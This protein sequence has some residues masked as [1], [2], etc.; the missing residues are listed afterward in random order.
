MTQS[1]TP[2]V[3][4][5]MGH[6]RRW[7]L[8]Q[9]LARSD[10]TVRD[11]VERLGK[12]QNLVSYHLAELRKAG[13]VSS[14]RS[15]ADGRD[16]YYRFDIRGCADLL[17]AAGAALTP[18]LSLAA[19]GDEPVPSTGRRPLVLFL[20]TGNSARS[21]MA[22]ALLE[23]LSKGSVRA[24]SAGSHPKPLH[25]NAVRVMSERGID[26]SG[27]QSKRLDRFARSKLDRVITLCD[28]VREICPEFPGSPVAAHWSMAD[29]AAG[30]GTDEESYPAF[31]RTADELETRILLL[32]TE[33]SVTTA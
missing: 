28:K 16:S 13:L 22:E 27:H 1:Q 8:L 17:C 33:L 4:R 24:L 14:R 26:I 2:E 9:E 25:P 32:L 6:D 23:H 29:P 19:P 10:L 3:L 18:A 30:T 5:L 31:V 11:L 20:C 15:S 7:R 12:P 21:Q